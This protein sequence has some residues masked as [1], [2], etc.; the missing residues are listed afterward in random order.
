MFLVSLK[1]NFDLL[2]SLWAQKLGFSP[3][4]NKY[5]ALCVV[6]KARYLITRYTSTE[7]KLRMQRIIN[8]KQQE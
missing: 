7:W 4:I 1:Q 6:F 8:L 5:T 3:F 2:T